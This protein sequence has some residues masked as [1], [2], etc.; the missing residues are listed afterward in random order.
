[1]SS[2]D[3]NE[4]DSGTLCSILE[5]ATS[6]AKAMMHEM[7]AAS[8]KKEKLKNQTAFVGYP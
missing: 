7:K 3:F 5:G 4:L 2:I 1:M 8:S 6:K